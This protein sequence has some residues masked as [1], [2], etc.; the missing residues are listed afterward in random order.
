MDLIKYPSSSI[1]VDLIGKKTNLHLIGSPLKVI[2]EPGFV[3][4]AGKDVIAVITAVHYMVVGT[5]ICYSF[6]SHVPYTTT[7]ATLQHS[8]AP[9]PDF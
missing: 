8:H 6:Q 4:V 9:S 3:F 1:I 7:S 5:W 2:Q